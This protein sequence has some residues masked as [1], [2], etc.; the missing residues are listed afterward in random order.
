MAQDDLLGQLLKEEKTDSALLPERMIIT[1][2][3][4]WGEKG[5]LRTTGIAPLGL[6]QRKREMQTRRFFLKTH[7]ALGFVLSIPGYRW[8]LPQ[9][10]NNH[11]ARMLMNSHTEGHN[12]PVSD[13]VN[14]S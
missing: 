10:K 9:K 1:Q 4:L 6:E 7:Q 11:K 14:Y 13:H 8:H 3:M 5:L 2:R 12:Q